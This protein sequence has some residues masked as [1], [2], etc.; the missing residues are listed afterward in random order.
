MCPDR[1]STVTRA[2]RLPPALCTSATEI[3]GRAVERLVEHRVLRRGQRVDAFLRQHRI[4]LADAER[5]EELLRH[6]QQEDVQPDQRVLGEA[7]A[8]RQVDDPSAPQVCSACGKFVYS[9]IEAILL[10]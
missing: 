9:W 7:V 1:F 6:L 10:R 4:G 8:R 2:L 5:L 3:V